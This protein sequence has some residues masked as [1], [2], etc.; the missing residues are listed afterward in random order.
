MGVGGGRQSA[1]AAVQEEQ[2]ERQ[3]PV[4]RSRC[5]RPISPPAPVQEVSRLAA[6]QLHGP[7]KDRQTGWEVGGRR[8]CGTGLGE[9]ASTI[10]AGQQWPKSVRGMVA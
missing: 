4:S 5:V 7:G 6:P 2:R 1:A 3:E 10:I 8:G 9:G